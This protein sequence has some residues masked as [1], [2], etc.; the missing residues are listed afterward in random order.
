MYNDEVRLPHR[1]S[2]RGT[3]APSLSSYGVFYEAS[4][5]ALFLRSQEKGGAWL[6]ALLVSRDPRRGRPDLFTL[7]GV[8]GGGGE[9]DPATHV[10]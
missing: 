1:P 9:R 2:G 5:R 8:L 7:S 10:P 6:G 4:Q 3:F